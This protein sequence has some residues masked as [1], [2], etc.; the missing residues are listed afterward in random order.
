MKSTSLLL[1]GL[2]LLLTAPWSS[3]AP[4]A[5]LQNPPGRSTLYLQLAWRRPFLGAF[6][7]CLHTGEEYCTLPAPCIICSM[8]PYTLSHFA[9]PSM[10]RPS[11]L[12]TIAEHCDRP[13][14]SNILCP[15]LAA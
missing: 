12:S 14:G 4:R 2:C 10:Y 5:L 9:S 15:H 8:L 1:T 7:S 11:N 6:Y 13:A 3:A